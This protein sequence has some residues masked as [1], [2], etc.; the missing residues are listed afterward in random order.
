MAEMETTYQIEMRLDVHELDAI[1]PG[2]PLIPLTLR[3]SQVLLFHCK[4]SW[5]LNLQASGYNPIFEDSSVLVCSSS[6][7]QSS[8]S[9]NKSNTCSRQCENINAN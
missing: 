8:R 2:T 3:N 1:F 7:L 5:S 9:R 4:H 6:H